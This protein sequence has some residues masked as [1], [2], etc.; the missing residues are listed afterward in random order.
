[1]SI[2]LNPEDQKKAEDLVASGRF[3]SINDALHAGLEAI[4]EDSEWQRYASDRIAAGLDDIA[5]G[6]T[7]P[8]EEVLTMLHTYNQKKA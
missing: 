2:T 5:A 1:M 6:R 4:E 8:A 7:L 3:S